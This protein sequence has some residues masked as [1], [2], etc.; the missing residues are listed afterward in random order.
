MDLLIRLREWDRRGGRPVSDPDP[1]D[2]LAAEGVGGR[3]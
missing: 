3:R 2:R 1:A